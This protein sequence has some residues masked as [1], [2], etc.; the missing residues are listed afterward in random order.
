MITSTKTLIISAG[1]ALTLLSAALPVHGQDHPKE[2]RNGIFFTPGIPSLSM[3]YERQLA[4]KKENR[5]FYLRGIGGQ[6][7]DLINLDWTGY[8]ALMP[9]WVFGTGNN[10]LETGVG[11]T[12]VSPANYPEV[13]AALNLGYRYQKP[14][15]AAI[16][17][18]GGSIPE[19]VY[20]SFGVAF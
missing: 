18:A 3:S 13:W 7:V 1:I 20:I 4:H 2:L 19:G 15:E 14:G 10:H 5:R 17:R 6:F 12:V 9:S 16:F 8:V 11:L